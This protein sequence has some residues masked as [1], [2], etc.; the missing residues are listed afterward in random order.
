MTPLEI[1]PT[2]LKNRLAL[3]EAI[4]LLDCREVIENQMARIEPSTLIPMNTIPA[5][6]QEIEALADEKLLVVYCHHGMRSLNT[7]QWLRQ[8]GEIGRAHV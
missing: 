1:L 6:L 7:V 8:Q 5:R 3:G 4:V 2:D